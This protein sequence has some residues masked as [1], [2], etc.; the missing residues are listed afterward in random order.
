MI[1]TIDPNS[2]DFD[3]EPLDL[4]IESDFD[5]IF[6]MAN[7]SCKIIEIKTKKD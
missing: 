5:R 3:D 2:Y 7:Y 1:G 4:E 6:I